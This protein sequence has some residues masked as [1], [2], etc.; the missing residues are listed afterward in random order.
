MFNNYPKK[1]TQD[2]ATSQQPYP[3]AALTL[4]IWNIVTKVQAHGG[5]RYHRLQKSI[6][7]HNA[8]EG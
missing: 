5:T 4:F 1:Q 6:H 8:I 2:K 3:I 7:N